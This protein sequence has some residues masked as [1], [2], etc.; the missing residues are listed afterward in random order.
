MQGIIHSGA[1]KSR[2]KRG[3]TLVE[4]IVVLAI[5]GLLLAFLVPAIQ[6]SRNAA[7][8]IECANHLRQLG[9]ALALLGLVAL[10]PVAWRKLAQRRVMNN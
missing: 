4:V 3:V 1:R 7:R 6:S 8:R 10:V 9:L 5:V 2:C